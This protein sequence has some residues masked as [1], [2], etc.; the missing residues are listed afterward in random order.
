MI[1]L[2]MTKAKTMTMTM[3]NGASQH[4]DD[5]EH[6]IFTAMAITETNLMMAMIV[7]LG[8]Q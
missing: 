2:V 3:C 6:E 5:H 4:Y 1:P 7:I 8:A